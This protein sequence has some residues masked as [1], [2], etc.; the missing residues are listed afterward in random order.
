MYQR[1]PVYSDLEDRVHQ[2]VRDLDLKVWFLDERLREIRRLEASGEFV[3]HGFQT[4]A[5]YNNR[6]YSLRVVVWDD[7][8]FNSARVRGRR[9]QDEL[10][11]HALKRPGFKVP[12]YYNAGSRPLDY[13]LMPH[14]G[15]FE[16]PFDMTKAEQLRDEVKYV[17][18]FL[19]VMSEISR[20]DEVRGVVEED[21]GAFADETRYFTQWAAKAGVVSPQTQ[22]ALSTLLDEYLDRRRS[23][24]VGLVHPDLHPGNLKLASDAARQWTQAYEPHNLRGYDHVIDLDGAVL[25]EPSYMPARHYAIMS[26][27]PT[28]Q[29][30]FLAGLVRGSRP[31][32]FWQ[33][34]L[35]QVVYKTLDQVH[36][37]L[38]RRPGRSLS[39]TELHQQNQ[40][41]A[42][43]VKN[44]LRTLDALMKS[45]L[46]APNQDLWIPAELADPVAVAL[47]SADESV[48][49][50][51]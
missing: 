25:G 41:R 37:D 7:P 12:P 50:S 30:H 20:I 39:L 21:W 29:R 36:F 11:A 27:E 33:D 40:G 44:N 2:V 26:H 14:V 32:G 16:L 45:F 48:R 49:L 5:D 43:I 6:V 18:R 28:W 17:G 13:D 19:T 31:P 34:F 1:R 8:E 22:Q 15:G 47:P 23:G 38:E 3:R 4:R 9:V 24:I 10:R 42:E 46:K 51:W 35:M